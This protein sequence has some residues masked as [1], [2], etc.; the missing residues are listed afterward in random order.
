MTLVV[1]CRPRWRYNMIVSGW[2]LTILSLISASF[3]TSIAG[4]IATQGVVYSVGF[5]VM[6][7]PIISNLNEWFIT[8]RGLAFGITNA[9]TGISGIAMPFVL[10]TLL[11]RYG[12]STTLRAIAVTLF[13]MTGPVLPMLRGR[14]PKTYAPSV[15]PRIDISFLKRPLFYFFAA[16]VLLQGLGHYYPTLFLPSYANSLGYSPNIGAL[17]LALFSCAQVPGQITVGYLSDKRMSAEMLAFITPLVSTVSILALWGPARSLT[18][19]IVFSLLYGFFGGGYVSLWAKMGLSLSDDPTVALVTFGVFCFLKGVG[20][21]IA[22]PIS[23][24]LLLQQTSVGAYGLERYKWVIS[25]SSVCMYACTSVMVVLF[26]G[27]QVLRIARG[28]NI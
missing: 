21:V 4:L 3:T 23:A 24:A 14:L 17:L 8:R 2:V 28:I 13:V 15:R 25:Y 19:L 10:A 18:P 16:S 22:G 5:S 11:D 6:Y 27:R 12:Y 1:R 20:N 26:I 7:F 9:A